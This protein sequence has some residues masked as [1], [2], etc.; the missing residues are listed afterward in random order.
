MA[1]TMLYIFLLVVFGKLLSPA[2][3]QTMQPGYYA[4]CADETYANVICI[5]ETYGVEIGAVVLAIVALFCACVLVGAAYL[6]WR[7]R[8]RRA[9]YARRRRLVRR[10]AIGTDAVETSR[11]SQAEFLDE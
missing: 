2:L 8:T 4:S 9:L 11:S 3:S 10:S 1:S 7:L 5:T 6:V